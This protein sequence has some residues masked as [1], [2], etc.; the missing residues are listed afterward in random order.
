MQMSNAA[1]EAAAN[2]RP[3]FLQ[4]EKRGEEDEEVDENEEKTSSRRWRKN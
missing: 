3:G 4:Q 2:C 1:A